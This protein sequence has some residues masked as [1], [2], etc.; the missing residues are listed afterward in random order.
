MNGNRQVT[1]LSMILALVVI[2]VGVGIMPQ[3]DVEADVL[4]AGLTLLEGFCST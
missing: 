3:M 4:Y 2:F 1:R